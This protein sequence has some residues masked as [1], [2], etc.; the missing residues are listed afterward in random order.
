MASNSK[1]QMTIPTDDGEMK[2][3]VMNIT[4]QK[5]VK[6]LGANT[7]NR[8]LRQ[9]RVNM[10]ASE[11]Q[12]GN[13]K[14][15]GVPIVFGTDG[16][17][18]DGQH[19][20]QACVKSGKTMKNTLVVYL[21]K[22]QAN[23]Y[24]IGAVRTP[25][26]IAKFAGLGEIPYYTNSNMFSAIRLAVAGRDTGHGY[27]K[28]T[29]VREMQKHPQACEF[30]YYKFMMSTSGSKSKLRKSAVAAAIFNAF[31]AGYPHEQLERFCKVLL[32]GKIKDE[33]EE[34]IITLRD[35]VIMIGAQNKQER[36]LLYYKTQM[37]LYAFAN[38]QSDIDFKKA[39]TEYYPY[40][41]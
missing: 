21:S 31:I 33:A 12:S 25:K 39:K 22:A 19:R 30:V 27:S 37:A 18:K 34:P 9:N 11:M 28:I 5:A 7:N 24:D 35:N 20:L 40:P 29:L 14:S 6:F 2:V 38:N 4:P 41:K 36:T 23:C 3:C 8:N 10:Y 1:N 13:W 15:N 17:L 32:D 16:E 26:D